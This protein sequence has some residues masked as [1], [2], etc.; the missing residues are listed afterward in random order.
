MSFRSFL[1][2][3]PQTVNNFQ[4]TLGEMISDALGIIQIGVD[5]ES[6]EPE[7]YERARVVANRVV[8]EMQMMGL[9]LSSY[10][11][12]YLFLQP[13][14]YK[15][16][17]EDENATNEYWSRQ[18]SADEASGQTVLSISSSDDLQVDDVIGI[19]LDDGSLQ[20]TTVTAVDTVTPTVTIADALT[21]DASTDNYIF[22][23]R[24][25]L[26][27]IS[28]VH[29]MWRR[30]NYVNDVP[31]TQLSQQEYDVL[32]FKTTSPGLPSQW[33]YHRAIPKGVLYLWT[34]PVNSTYIIGFW[35][36]CKLGQLKDPTD[37][38]DMDQFYIPF[39]VQRLALRC[40]ESF[41]A[42]ADTLNRVRQTDEEL[43]ALS[44]SYDDE[45]AP[46]KISPNLR[47]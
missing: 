34:I 43:M 2:Y 46:I 41:A 17:I 30:D 25:T 13:D 6:V 44:L 36:E 18:I 19:T 10:K 45:G 42:S 24:T 1:P 3:E 20:W 37:V 9:H 28:R 40:G 22:N 39:F 47:T 14:Q 35:Y 27:Q 5:G 4:L 23:Y 38:I 12:G 7:Y 29:Q 31:I 8:L 26:R 33:Y 15:Y 11:V 32:P 16:V 21:D